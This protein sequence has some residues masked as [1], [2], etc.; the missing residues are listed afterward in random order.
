M[1]FIV[2]A[3][4]LLLA[5]TVLGGSAWAS[6]HYVCRMSGRVVSSCCCSSEHGSSA[7]RRQPGARPA[8]CCERIAPSERSSVA[9]QRAGIEPS[10]L[11]GLAATVP[12]PLYF[13][14]LA[15]VRE[16]VRNPGRG[17]PVAKQPRYVVHCAYLC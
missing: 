15:P 10:E 12:L 6:D 13:P 14:S 1:R 7:Q 17:P 3:L 2:R 5:L 8:D 16:L 4:V 11:V 9:I